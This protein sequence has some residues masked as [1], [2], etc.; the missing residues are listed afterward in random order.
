MRLLWTSLGNFFTNHRTVHWNS[1]SALILFG[2]GEKLSFP[3]R[4]RRLLADPAIPSHLRGLL[5]QIILQLGQ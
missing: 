5:P 3:H 4:Y 2:L 1:V